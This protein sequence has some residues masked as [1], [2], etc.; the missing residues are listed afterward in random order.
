MLN[1]QRSLSEL[2]KMSAASQVERAVLVSTALCVRGSRRR[3]SLGPVGPP[4][5]LALLAGLQRNKPLNPANVTFSVGRE[6]YLMDVCH[7]VTQVLHPPSS[8]PPPP[9]PPPRCRCLSPP[10]GRGRGLG[11]STSGLRSRSVSVL[12][13]CVCVSVFWQRSTRHAGT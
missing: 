3:S 9:P 6:C 12:C 5:T 7:L 1:S 8:P 10:A 4:L 13:V 2:P 11:L